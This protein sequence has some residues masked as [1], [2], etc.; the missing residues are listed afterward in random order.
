MRKN[1]EEKISLLKREAKRDEEVDALLEIVALYYPY[2]L[3]NPNIASTA[4]IKG[5]NRLVRANISN[6]QL[7]KDLL[8]EE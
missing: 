7:K 6:P 2:M 3:E 5:Y 1:Y 8:I 4:M